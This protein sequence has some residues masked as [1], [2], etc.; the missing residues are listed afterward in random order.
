MAA[1]TAC[2][3]TAVDAAIATPPRTDASAA[4]TEAVETAPFQVRLP[5]LAGYQ[6]I[7]VQTVSEP[8]D[9]TGHRASV[10]ARLLGADGTL[11]HVFQTNV[12]PEAMGTSDPLVVPGA[13]QVTVDASDWMEVVLPSGDGGSLVQ[14]AK[15]IGEVTISIDSSSREVARGAA[16]ALEIVEP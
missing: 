5:L 16:A 3:L 8:N 9:P 6:V 13:K 1:L 10:D 4:L 12:L 15:R 11:V 14:L 7:D 2:G